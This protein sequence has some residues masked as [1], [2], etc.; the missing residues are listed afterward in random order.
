MMVKEKK[1]EVKPKS[2]AEKFWN[3]TARKMIFRNFVGGNKRK[4]LTRK[5]K[6]RRAKQRR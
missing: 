5:N 6:I 2:P 3:A 4:Q 1:Q